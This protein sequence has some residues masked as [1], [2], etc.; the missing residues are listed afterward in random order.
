[1][2][3][4]L[5]QDPKFFSL[6]LQID[7]EL[8]TTRRAQGCVCGGRLHAAHYPRKPR[9]LLRGA[10]GDDIRRLSFCCNRCRKRAAARS[11]RFLGR[12]VWLALAVVLVSPRPPTKTAPG[13]WAVLPVPVRTLRR[14][15]RWWCE[16]FPRTPFWRTAQACFMPPVSRAELPPAL[17]ERF[18]GDHAAERMMRL[19]HFLTPLTVGGASTHDEG[20]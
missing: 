12:R 10:W 5:L 20:R 13:L 18:A 17:L 6:L 11:V 1:V 19:L 7:E 15:Q 4:L 9:G 8:A 3:H 16:H 14:W 2:C